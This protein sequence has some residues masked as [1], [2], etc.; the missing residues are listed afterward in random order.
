MPKN[1]LKKDTPISARLYPDDYD[2]FTKLAQKQELS[3]AKLIVQLMDEHLQRE[4]ELSKEVPIVLDISRKTT[5]PDRTEYAQPKKIKFYGKWLVCPD[6]TSK[7]VD[8]VI[9]QKLKEDF[10]LVLDLDYEYNFFHALNLLFHSSENR[11]IIQE[12]MYVVLQ[13]EY[14]SL[15]IEEHPFLLN[16]CKFVDSY[17]DVDKYFGRYASSDNLSA[18]SMCLSEEI[19]TDYSALDELFIPYQESHNKAE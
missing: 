14:Y 5:F 1:K 10:G 13:N 12:R 15:C 7:P 19:G 6:W 18:I 3:Y 9:A 17:A 8:R 11:Y 2:R 4:E 16:R